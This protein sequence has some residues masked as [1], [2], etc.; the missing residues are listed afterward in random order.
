MNA[1]DCYFDLIQIQ[2]NAYK[3]VRLIYHFA[4]RKSLSITDFIYK[5]NVARI[6]EWKKC[7]MQKYFPISTYFYAVI[8]KR[9]KFQCIAQFIEHTQMV[10]L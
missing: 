1:W 6:D 3:S 10:I 4:R 9:N 7:K 5:Y 8:P 2:N